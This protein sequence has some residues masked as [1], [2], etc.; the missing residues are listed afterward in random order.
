MAKAAALILA[1]YAGFPLLELEYNTD[2]SP[3]QG[4]QSLTISEPPPPLSGGGSSFLA[5]TLESA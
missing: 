5:E 3:G 4:G 1:L 2:K